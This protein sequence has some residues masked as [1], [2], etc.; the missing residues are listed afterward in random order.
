MDIFV[1]LI[2]WLHSTIIAAP[3]YGKALAVLAGIGAVYGAFQAVSGFASGIYNLF[4]GGPKR[5]RD[6]AKQREEA[7]LRFEDERSRDAAQTR[8]IDDLTKLVQK[9]IAN[10]DRDMVS[11]AASGGKAS[12]AMQVR[13][14]VEAAAED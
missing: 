11:G 7:R 14:A 12:E 4:I 10:A 6:E 13:E 2:D 8:K 9:L 5:R 3:L 1:S